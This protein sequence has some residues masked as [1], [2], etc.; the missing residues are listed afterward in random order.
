M[1]KDFRTIWKAEGSTKWSDKIAAQ[2]LRA[3]CLGQTLNVKDCP[4]YVLPQNGY[5]I[6]W[7]ATLVA[8]IQKKV[9]FSP[10]IYPAL[11]WPWRDGF[12]V[13][14]K[15][16]AAE[17]FVVDKTTDLILNGDDIVYDPT[18]ANVVVIVDD[19]AGIVRA[20]KQAGISVPEKFEDAIR[21]YRRFRNEVN[22]ALAARAKIAAA[23]N[24]RAWRR[25]KKGQVPEGLIPLPDYLAA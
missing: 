4:N 3:Y 1:L 11:S 18:T 14:A 5:G 15:L 24:A 16:S 12:K 9:M 20:A 23:A 22:Y 6:F 25:A 10:N 8:D 13:E 2:L 19:W 21:P 7:L 17:Q